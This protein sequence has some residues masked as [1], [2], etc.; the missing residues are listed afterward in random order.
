[1]KQLNANILTSVAGAVLGVVMVIGF[2]HSYFTQG[3]GVKEFQIHEEAI[4][5]YDNSEL[6]TNPKIALLNELSSIPVQVVVDQCFAGSDSTNVPIVR[7]KYRYLFL[8]E[9][10]SYK[11][12]SR[13]IVNNLEK[14]PKLRI[15]CP[16]SNRD[17][18]IYKEVGG[19]SIQKIEF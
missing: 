7:F 9:I 12:L 3:D 16:E 18:L 17:F 19:S 8:E 10:F 14:Y 6:E 15:Y 2:V 5:I 1:M 4:R 13:E 11:D